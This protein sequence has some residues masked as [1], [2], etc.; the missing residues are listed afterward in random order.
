MKEGYITVFV[1]LILG[2][3]LPLYFLLF[4]N[5]VNAATA[6][7]ANCISDVATESIMAEYSV[8]MI[9]LQSILPTGWRHHPL[10]GRKHI[11]IT[12]LI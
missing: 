8:D 3:M 4:E 5:A 1:S 6:V 10:E 7:E 11:L 2:T 12:I 9:C